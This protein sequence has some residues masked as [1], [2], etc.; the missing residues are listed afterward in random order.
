MAALEYRGKSPNTDSSVVPKSWAD[1]QS[2]ATA[3]T[4]NWVNSQIATEAA[5]DVL[6]TASYVDAQDALRAHKTDVD[7]ADTAYVPSTARGVSVASLDANGSLVGSQ[8]PA[9]LVTSRVAQSYTAA[10]NGTVYLAPGATHQVNTTTA[11]EF[12]LATIPIADPGYPWRPLTLGQVGGWS[13]FTIPSDRFTGTGNLGM[14][15]V[16]PPVEVAD[17]VYGAA[18][19]TGAYQKLSFYPILPFGTGGTTPLSVPAINGALTLELWGC[20]YSSTDYVFS[21][22][23]LVFTVLVIPAI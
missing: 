15:R 13:V 21:G 20:C 8:V 3:V 2:A 19:C 5:N 10:A 4:T 14:V 16:M 23:G 22:T 12:R 6:Q 7:A 17:T 9:G 1:T 11:R 18:V